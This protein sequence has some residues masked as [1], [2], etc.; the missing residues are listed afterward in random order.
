MATEAARFACAPELLLK[1]TELRWLLQLC[2]RG[3]FANKAA[4][5]TAPG[6]GFAKQKAALPNL[7]AKDPA[8]R[9]GGFANNLEA[10][11]PRR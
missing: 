1:M 9:K 7:G 2:R 5:P 4:L 6:G 10:A 11:L 8:P 3:G